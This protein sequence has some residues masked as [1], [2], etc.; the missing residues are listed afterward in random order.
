MSKSPFYY[1]FS[2]VFLITNLKFSGTINFIS[3]WIVHHPMDQFRTQL[4]QW[5]D[6]LCLFF[7]NRFRKRGGG[8]GGSMYFRFHNCHVINTVYKGSAS[9]FGQQR[10]SESNNTT[11]TTTPMIPNIIYTGLSFM[12]FLTGLLALLITV[13]RLCRKRFPPEHSEF[14]FILSSVVLT[15]FSFVESF[16]WIFLFSEYMVGSIACQVLAVFRE[17]GAVM[18]LALIVCIGLHLCII[19]W[20]PK[21]LM[22]IN[23]EKKR[24]YRKLTLCYSLV[25]FLVPLL[26][27]PWPFFAGGNHNHYGPS[28]YTCWI[29]EY[30]E[31]CN[32][33]EVGLVEQASLFYLWAFFTALLLAVVVVMVS[34][35]LFIQS[36]RRCTATSCTIIVMAALL[37]IAAIVMWLLFVYDIKFGQ[38]QVSKLWLV[39]LQAVCIPSC[40]TIIN[41][42]LFVRT[43][44]VGHVCE[45]HGNGNIPVR[46]ERVRNQV[47]CLHEAT[48]MLSTISTHP[49]C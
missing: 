11:T 9:E 46:V 29:S 30:D 18:I 39:Y 33:S 13:S 5:F 19:T 26:F 25:T 22:V 48:P 14:L 35:I 10:C 27:V 2:M 37:V 12:S 17:Y 21:W 41:V 44:Y 47:A 15:I 40:V 49:S 34:L 24:L 28:D 3:Y 32:N 31:N 6:S 16:Q 1:Y 38:Q 23:E 43:C 42:A 20:N 45:Q 36:S 7:N 4:L 8:E